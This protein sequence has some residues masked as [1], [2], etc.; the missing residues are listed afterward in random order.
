MD[1]GIPTNS[2]SPKVERK[3]QEAET[4]IGPPLCIKFWWYKTFGALDNT[5]VILME[6]FVAKHP[7]KNELFDHHKFPKNHA[8]ELGYDLPKPF[9]KC[10]NHIFLHKT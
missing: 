7:L 4:P 5:P 9:S 10:E 3:N 8:I 1:L 2:D 6:E